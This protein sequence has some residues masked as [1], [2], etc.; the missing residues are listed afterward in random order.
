MGGYAKPDGC[1]PLPLNSTG[2]LALAELSG[3]DLQLITDTE[4]CG[5]AFMQDPESWQTVIGGR[6]RLNLYQLGSRDVTRILKLLQRYADIRPNLDRLSP[7]EENDV[8]LLLELLAE[9]GPLQAVDGIVGAGTYGMQSFQGVFL[10]K[11]RNLVHAL[12]SSWSVL[13]GGGT[14]ATWRLKSVLRTAEDFAKDCVVEPRIIEGCLSYRVRPSTLNSFLWGW[15]LV[16]AGQEASWR[17][18]LY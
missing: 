13:N 17:S 11:Y 16:R 1:I 10:W 7:V 5:K 9:C 12:G 15:L 6:T 3:N 4:E 14:T 18:C 8:S 2:G